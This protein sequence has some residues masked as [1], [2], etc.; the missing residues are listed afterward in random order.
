MIFLDL[1]LIA[2]SIFVFS[3]LAYAGVHLSHEYKKAVASYEN[4]SKAERITIRS[5]DGNE[6][7]LQRTPYVEDNRTVVL[8]NNKKVSESTNDNNDL[9][10]MVYRN[11]HK[12][13]EIPLTEPI[14]SIRIGRDK[15]NDIII[16]DAGISRFHAVITKTGDKISINDCFSSNGTFINGDKV[17]ASTSLFPDDD[18]RFADKKFRLSLEYAH[19][20]T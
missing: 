13:S 14:A 16:N 11:E 6:L 9:K 20:D 2:F 17:T 3:S 18:I 7:K 4:Q 5:Q 1:F 10:L 8:N 12:I 15:S 19:T